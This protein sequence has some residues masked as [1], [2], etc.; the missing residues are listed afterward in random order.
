MYPVTIVDN[1]FEDPDAIVRESEKMTFIPTDT[2]EWP[3]ERTKELWEVNPRMF[4]YVGGRIHSLFYEGI[5]KEWTMRLR[6]QRITPYSKDKWNRKN[7]GWVHQDQCPFG[8]VVYLTKDPDPDSGTS[9]FRLKDGYS[10]QWPFEE[11][12]KK[13]LYTGNL[14]ISQEEY[15]KVYDT[16]HD[17]YIETVKVENV[18]N[19]LVLFG[20]LALHGVQTFGTK[21]RLTLNFFED[22]VKD[23]GRR[24]PL[25]RLL[26]VW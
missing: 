18:Y 4:N 5:V 14:T 16:V 6:F 12:V 10:V 21:P 25:N 2:G 11:Q 17:Q 9:I 15:D 24:S 7:R 8:G 19:R 1:F 13:D 23:L 26:S 20:G 22:G 3:G